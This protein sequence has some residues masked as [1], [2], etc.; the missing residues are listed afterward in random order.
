MQVFYPEGAYGIESPLKKEKNIIHLLQRMELVG[1]TKTMM[2]EHY[3]QLLH[4]EINQHLHMVHSNL[5]V[6]IG[7]LHQLVFNHLNMKR[8]I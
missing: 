1:I 4:M 6:V 8:M 3:G 2:V 7:L 5:V